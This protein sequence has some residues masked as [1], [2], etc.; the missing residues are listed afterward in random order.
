M[1]GQF[2]TYGGDLVVE[3]VDG[4]ELV[5]DGRDHGAHF[6]DDLAAR[7][8]AACGD[9]ATVQDVARACD[10]S[11]ADAETVLARLVAIGLVE[12]DERDGGVSRRQALRQMAGAALGVGLV[13]S[14]VAPPASA[15][16]SGPVNDLRCP[17]GSPYPNGVPSGGCIFGS[18]HQCCSGRAY[19]GVAARPVCGRGGQVCL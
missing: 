4:G 3:Q 14:T 16:V 12:S 17:A 2:F 13:V 5:Y 15:Q 19:G 10:V 1:R 11:V 9:G 18:P 6:L 8:R 7:A